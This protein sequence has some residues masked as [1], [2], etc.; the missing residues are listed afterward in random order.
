MLVIAIGMAMT[1]CSSYKYVGKLYMDFWGCYS[2][3]IGDNVTRV[4]AKGEPYYNPKLK[5]PGGLGKKEFIDDFTRM[6][7]L[8]DFIY[9]TPDEWK[10]GKYNIYLIKD[11]DETRHV[12]TITIVLKRRY[13]NMGKAYCV[14]DSYPKAYHEGKKING[15]RGVPD[16]VI[17]CTY[18]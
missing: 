15:C 14:R 2:E 4:N 7:Y 12:Y 5:D 9:V 16:H 11:S 18:E 3:Y 10:G 8:A 17:L 6:P 1:S 13:L